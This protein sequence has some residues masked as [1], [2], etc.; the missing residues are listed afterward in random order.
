MENI[1]KT[2]YMTS[3]TQKM[4]GAWKITEVLIKGRFLH[5]LVSSITTK[6]IIKSTIINKGM[7]S[8]N[9]RRLFINLREDRK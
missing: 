4:R 5:F 8:Y 6:R 7:G 1:C 2:K 3:I 9:N